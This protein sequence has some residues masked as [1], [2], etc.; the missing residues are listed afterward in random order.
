V[1]RSLVALRRAQT[2]G[3]SMGALAPHA[4]MQRQGLTGSMSAGVRA[5]IL[6]YAGAANLARVTHFTMDR[7]G[8]DQWT[9]VGQDVTDA[10]RGAATAKVIPTVNGATSQTFH[11]NLTRVATEQ[12]IDGTAQPATT[13]AD[14]LMP[15]ASLNAAASLGATQR[16]ADYDALLRVENQTMNSSNTHRLRELPRGHTGAQA[17]CRR[18]LRAVGDG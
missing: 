9:F 4:I 14:D 12:A 18:D 3:D 7:T 10:T 5:I 8:G 1:A 6:A 2:D 17:G 11:G 16:Q 13:S 15:L